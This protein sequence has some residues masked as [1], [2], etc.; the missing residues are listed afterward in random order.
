MQLNPKGCSIYPNFT[1][2]KLLGLKKELGG[3]SRSKIP[4]GRASSQAWGEV[5]GLKEAKRKVRFQASV[6]TMP[7]CVTPSPR[8]RTPTAD[9]ENF[10]PHTSGFADTCPHPGPSSHEPIGPS[11]PTD[12]KGSQCLSKQCGPMVSRRTITTNPRRKEGHLLPRP[13]GGQAPL[14]APT[15]QDLAVLPLARPVFTF[16]S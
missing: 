3:F 9:T 7:R 5:T 4:L 13:S 2:V 11:H 15:T 8:R 1:Y 10:G 14:V 6:L 16:C 12:C